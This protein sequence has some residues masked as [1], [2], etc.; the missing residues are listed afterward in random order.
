MIHRLLFVKFP[1]KTLHE[2]KG[3]FGITPDERDE[4]QNAFTSWIPNFKTETLDNNFI[5]NS[6][7]EV[8]S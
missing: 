8:L 6:M 3:S 5:T 7:E 4:I 2:K 1:S